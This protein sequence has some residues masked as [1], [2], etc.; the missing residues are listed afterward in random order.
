VHPDNLSWE[1]APKPRYQA[2][3]SGFGG[4]REFRE[5]RGK[6]DGWSQRRE[7]PR[8]RERRT[9]GGWSESGGNTGW[10]A[11]AD[12]GADSSWGVGKERRESQSGRERWSKP[13]GGWGDDRGRNAKRSEPA[14][15]G[16][17][18]SRG[19][20]KEKRESQ[21]AGGGGWSK[22]SSGW[23]NTKDSEWGSTGWSQPSFEQTGNE[24][25][26][27]ADGWANA[28]WGNATGNTNSWGN[29][30][31]SANN[32]GNTW[33]NVA[34]SSWGNTVE[35][36]WDNIT[37]SPSKELIGEKNRTATADTPGKD[38]E[39]DR[40]GTSGTATTSAP[41]AVSDSDAL[42]NTAFS[43]AGS[44]G[45]SLVT[46]ASPTVYA[47]TD[48]WSTVAQS[49][50]HA[51]ATDTGRSSSSRSHD[52]T[53]ESGELTPEIRSSTKDKPVPT[54]PRSLRIVTSGCSSSDAFS[55][56][57]QAEPMS[58]APSAA[59][60]EASGST[61][62]GAG[63]AAEGSSFA[64]PSAT[65]D[66]D[67]AVATACLQG[68]PRMNDPT[69]TA[70]AVDSVATAS[71]RRVSS[72]SSKCASMSMDMDEPVIPRRAR[73]ELPPLPNTTLRAMKYVHLCF[74][75]KL[76]Y[77]ILMGDIS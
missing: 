38:K 75:L 50:T 5:P 3:S 19:F 47:D 28:A 33:G 1:T 13:S 32:W 57:T 59:H 64:G 23:T 43:C 61:P 41:A 77:F 45:S 11:P 18:S 74:T 25:S 35:A 40:T 44:T 63:H 48:G 73:P 42:G 46:A 26:S 15:A 51:Q 31:D 76:C 37:A 52:S 2:S 30:T 70:I 9:S 65:M 24:G 71:Q 53:L 67:K 6:D 39:P 72:S 16:A 60:N 36:S 12:A 34:G 68:A 56:R 58:S 22:P 17:D 69:N 21:S 4:R 7:F 10:S 29:T 49:G 66:E 55:K 8:D 20:S 14:D 62:W 27:N 54:G